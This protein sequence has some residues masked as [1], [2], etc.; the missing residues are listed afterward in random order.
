MSLSTTVFDCMRLSR[1]FHEK[2][3]QDLENVLQSEK[4]ESTPPFANKDVNCAVWRQ[5]QHDQLIR[6]AERVQHL[7]TR[8]YQSELGISQSHGRFSVITLLLR[9]R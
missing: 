8:S 3:N 4:T 7:D 1:L 2:D 6:T 9:V 5:S